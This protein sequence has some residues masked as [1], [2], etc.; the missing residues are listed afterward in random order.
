M[1]KKLKLVV[2]LQKIN[3]IALFRYCELRG[4]AF[5]VFDQMKAEDKEDEEKIE[6][7]LVNAF[8]GTSAN[9]GDRNV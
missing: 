9:F 5:S 3:K 2:K 7:A 1:V 4:N 8:G 6:E